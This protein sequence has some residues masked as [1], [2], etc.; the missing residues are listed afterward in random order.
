MIDLSHLREDF[1]ILTREFGGKPVAYLDSAA[2]TQKPIQV[3]DA[4]D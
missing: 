2:T 4:M 1:P 3:L